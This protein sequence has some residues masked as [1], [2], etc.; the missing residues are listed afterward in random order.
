MPGFK[1]FV[2]AAKTTVSEA[3]RAAGNAL[4]RE[5]WRQNVAEVWGITV[6]Q[7][8]DVEKEAKRLSITDE[9]LLSPAPGDEVMN[10]PGMDGLKR[11]YREALEEQSMQLQ[12]LAQTQGE[13]LRELQQL[14]RLVAVQPGALLPEVRVDP[15]S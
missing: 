12:S 1:D 8:L 5:Q 11:K 15:K 7:V 4:K 13:I 14:V 6:E 10:G 9:Q 2:V 3:A